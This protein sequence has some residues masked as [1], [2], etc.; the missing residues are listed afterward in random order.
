MAA[1]QSAIRKNDN[2]VVIAGKDRGSWFIPDVGDEVLV[3]FEHGD[4]A[5][6]YVIG[7]LWNGSDSPPDSMDGAGKNNR[8]VI[9]SRAGVKITFDDTSGQVQLIIETPGGQKV[10]SPAVEAG[11]RLLRRPKVPA[12]LPVAATIREARHPDWRHFLHV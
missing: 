12:T 4:P 10:T 3:A 1:V 8:K 6:P 7:G 11:L 9:K 2:V 5:R